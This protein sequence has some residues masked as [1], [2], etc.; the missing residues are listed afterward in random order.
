MAEHSSG[1]GDTPPPLPGSDHA[2]QT[3]GNLDRSLAMMRF[4]RANCPWDAE[5]THESLVP[6]LLEESHEVVD[7]IHSGDAGQLEGELGDL[8][9]NLAFQIVVAEEA[10]TMTADSVTRRI[11][12]PTCTVWA[13]RKA[14]NRSRPASGRSGRR[15]RRRWLATVRRQTLTQRVTE[16]PNPAQVQAGRMTPSRGF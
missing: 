14:G 9:L 6:Y 15:W 3:R 7:A 5:Q 11:D 8:L 4:L 1:K 16:P 2:E 13:Q 10:G 12:T